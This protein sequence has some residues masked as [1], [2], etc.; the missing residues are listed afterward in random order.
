MDYIRSFSGKSGMKKRS[1]MLS[2]N[3]F[4][5][6]QYSDDLLKNAAEKPMLHLGED[7]QGKKKAVIIKTCN[8]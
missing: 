5:F 4:T 6:F 7:L 8:R 3:L 2:C 1:I